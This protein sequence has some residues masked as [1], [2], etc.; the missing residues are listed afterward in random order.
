MAKFKVGDKVR[1]IA[2]GA[3]GLPIGTEAKVIEVD[4]DGAV[5]L[6]VNNVYGNKAF[7][8]ACNIE[9]V[10]P[11]LT[12]NQRITTLEQT[13]ADLQAEVE[14]LKAAQKLPTM[15]V[16]AD[17]DVAKIA[18]SLAKAIE[19]LAPKSPNEQ[20]KAIIDEAKAFVVELSDIIR[21]AH[22]RETKF[23]RLNDVGCTFVL[24]PEFHINDKKRVVT[25]LMKG[26]NVDRGK[27]YA[28]A[29][30]KCAPG[31]VFNEHIGKAIALGR[32]LG[33]DVSKFE[34]AV[35]PSEVVVGMKIN[36]ESV[37]QTVSELIDTPYETLISGKKVSG[38]AFNTKES[39]GRLA[40]SQVTI[41]DDTEAQY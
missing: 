23:G 10:T 25:V 36:D 17:V 30:A 33:L 11:K 38:Q 34:K 8:L 12:K 32:A 31:D 41:A 40:Q 24:K 20:R 19:K 9:L 37:I 22:E 29:V 26:A 14:A 1:I 6:D 35:Q 21:G 27:I 15:T 16:K 4:R 18:E 28:K 13:V 39:Y 7:Y 5:Y 3:A 2:E